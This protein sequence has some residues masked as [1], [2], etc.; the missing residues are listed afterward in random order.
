[1]KKGNYSLELEVVVRN[2]TELHTSPRKF[3]VESSMFDRLD[4]L[5]MVQEIPKL[6]N[7]QRV[8]VR[9]KVLAQEE[10]IEVKKGLLKQEYMI[11][12]A[13]GSCKIVA[14]NTN[15][16]VLQLGSCLD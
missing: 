10:E 11:A 14:C 15:T 6:S 5:V 16:G 1:M 4:D 2:N 9:V 3:N 7:Y 13:T 12:D 8:S